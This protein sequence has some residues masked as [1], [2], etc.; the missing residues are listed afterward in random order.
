MGEQHTH[1]AEAYIGL[2][3]NLDKPL[4]QLESA[5]EQLKKI[6]EISLQGCSSFYRSAALGPKDQN[7]YINAVGYLRTSLSP[8]ELLHQCQHIENQ[9]GR[10][11]SGERWGPRVLDLDILLYRPFSTEATSP[12]PWLVRNSPEL[13]L[14]HPEIQNRSFV[15]LPLLELNPHLEIEI[16]IPLSHLRQELS[17]QTLQKLPVTIEP[18]L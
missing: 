14:P 3:A 9:H 5:L 2:G 4:Q 6:P 12:A 18:R 7:D 11:R 16:G 17:N 8:L 1:R 13:S 15:V 10:V